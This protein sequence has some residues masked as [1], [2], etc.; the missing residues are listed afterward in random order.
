MVMERRVR[1]L[2][3]HLRGNNIPASYAEDRSGA[4]EKIMSMIP[5]GSLV[6]FGDSL[7]LRQVGVVE[8]LRKGHYT[9]LDPCRREHA[10]Q[11]AGP[12][13]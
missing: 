10:A 6:G 11:A 9:F 8:A 1:D 12:H 4:L 7:T 3:E 5:E 2:I 13:F